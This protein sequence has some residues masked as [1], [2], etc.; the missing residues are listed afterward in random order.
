MG[1]E[2][3]YGL[4]CFKLRLGPK[5]LG[6]SGLQIFGH[7]CRG[8]SPELSPKS[9]TGTSPNTRHLRGQKPRSRLSYNANCSRCMTLYLYNYYTCISI[10][11]WVHTW[12]VHSRQTLRVWRPGTHFLGHCPPVCKVSSRWDCVIVF[13]VPGCTV[14]I[15]CSLVWFVVEYTNRM[16]AVVSWSLGYTTSKLITIP[17]Y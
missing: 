8:G 3:F 10:F 16:D 7:K 13:S 1:H 15:Q 14:L 4:L 2:I 5:V 6:P 11:S 12:Q 17:S 9:A